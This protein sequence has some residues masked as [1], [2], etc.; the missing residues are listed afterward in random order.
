MNKI[1][2]SHLAVELALRE[3]AV[4]LA[5]P[6]LKAIG[7]NA[8]DYPAG[9]TAEELADMGFAVVLPPSAYDRVDVV[10]K[11]L[12]GNTRFAAS[13]FANLFFEPVDGLLCGI[14]VEA[15]GLHPATN[16]VRGQVQLPLASLNFVSQELKAL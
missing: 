5:S 12:G 14:R 2:K 6:S 3:F 16:L 11:L 15:V 8:L 1:D 10:D 4:A 13:P 7:P 9:E